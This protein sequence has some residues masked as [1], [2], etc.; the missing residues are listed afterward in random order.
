MIPNCKGCEEELFEIERYSQD[1][2]DLYFA[3]S[4]LYEKGHLIMIMVNDKGEIIVG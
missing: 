1:G 4:G 2:Y 3:G